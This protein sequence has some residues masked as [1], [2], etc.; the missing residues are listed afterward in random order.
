MS[1]AIVA[2]IFT[3]L[4]SKPT[5]S[6]LWRDTICI[7]KGNLLYKHHWKYS[8]EQK[9]IS[10]LV[11]SCVEIQKLSPTHPHCY[12]SPFSCEW[13]ESL[14]WVTPALIPSLL[15]HSCRAGISEKYTL[16]ILL[17][18]RQ[19]RTPLSLLFCNFSSRLLSVVVVCTKLHNSS[20]SLCLKHLVTPPIHRVLLSF[21]KVYVCVGTQKWWY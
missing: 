15:V 9:T 10:V 14:L 13:V 19:H 18:Q 20:T 12:E 4:D 3:T 6:L 17:P 21:L 2:N 16:P 5:C 8:S 11:A 1:F 7:F